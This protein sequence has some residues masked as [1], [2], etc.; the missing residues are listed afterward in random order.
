M[1]TGAGTCPGVVKAQNNR[2]AYPDR[3]QFSIC[4]PPASGRSQYQYT[5][6]A[7]FGQVKKCW[8]DKKE[9][10][11]VDRNLGSFSQKGRN[12]ENRLLNL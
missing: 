4:P 11:I 8:K 6:L 9:P 12:T 7:D 2:I 1:G 3:S 5:T 10:E